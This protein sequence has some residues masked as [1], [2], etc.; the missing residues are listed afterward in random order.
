MVFTSILCTNNTKLITLEESCITIQIYFRRIRDFYGIIVR[1][2][3]ASEA[4]HLVELGRKRGSPLAGQQLGARAAQ[5]LGDRLLGLDLGVQ[6]RLQRE[7]L[8]LVQFLRAPVPPASRAR[9]TT[10]RRGR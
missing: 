3:K 9:W 7:D 2:G 4:L 1:L 6:R 5:L 8:H 10:A